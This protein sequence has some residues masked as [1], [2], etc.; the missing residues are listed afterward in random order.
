MHLKR[1]KPIERKIT[2][3]VLD[4]VLSRLKGQADL[5]RAYVRAAAISRLGLF[6]V[7][8]RRRLLLNNLSI[9]LPESSLKL[10]KRIAKGIVKNI[11]RGFVDLFYHA[12]H[13]ALIQNH[14]REENGDVMDAALARGKGCVVVTGHVG[15]FPW[16][17]IPIVAR[18]V[19]FAPVAR[20]PHEETLK[21]AFDDARS[22]IGYRSIPDRPPLTVFKESRKVLKRGGAVMITFDMHPAG[23]GGLPINFMGRKTPMFSFAVRLAAKSGAPLVPAHTLLEGNGFDHRIIFY[24]PITVPPEAAEEDHPKTGALL[25]QLAD[26]LAGIIREH[27]DHWWGLYRRWRPTDGDG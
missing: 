23:R 11:G 27:P 17:G 22:R 1:L 24:P 10:R 18:G 2:Q 7:R 6:L 12:Y 16:I 26:W 21:N 14:I 25:Q 8:P 9:A 20:D 3:G 13:P 5:R 4:A 19:E 15:M